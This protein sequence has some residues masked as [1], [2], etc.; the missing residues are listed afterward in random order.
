[1]ITVVV[2]ILQN[3]IFAFANVC[4]TYGPSIKL[5][6]AQSHFQCRANKVR[7]RMKRLELATLYWSTIY[8]RM[9]HQNNTTAIIKTVKTLHC[10]NLL[11]KRMYL[12]NLANFLERIDHRD[13]N[14]VS[15]IEQLVPS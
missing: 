1:M 10:H 12:S 14:S 15:L 6:Q 2:I 4:A 7:S 9:Q 13:N 3:G 8:H 11:A 5:F